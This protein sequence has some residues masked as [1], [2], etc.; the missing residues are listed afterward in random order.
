MQ[1]AEQERLTETRTEG[2]PRMKWAPFPVRGNRDRPG[3]NH[4]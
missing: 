4:W 2:V 1:N 3:G